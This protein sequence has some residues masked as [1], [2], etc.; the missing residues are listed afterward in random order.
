MPAAARPVPDSA[1]CGGGLSKEKKL[2]GS[3]KRPPD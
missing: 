1:A 3:E 2:A